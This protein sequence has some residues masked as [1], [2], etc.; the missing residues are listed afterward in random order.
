HR[1]SFVPVGFVEDAIRVVSRRESRCD[2]RWRKLRN[3]PRRIDLAVDH[4][5]IE[6]NPRRQYHAADLKTLLHREVNDENA[7]NSAR[8]ANDQHETAAPRTDE[9]GTD[10][11]G[12]DQQSGIN[13]EEKRPP[14]PGIE[15]RRPR[16]VELIV[17]D[18]AEEIGEEEFRQALPG[19]APRTDETPRKWQ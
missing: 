5:Q 1:L 11:Q 2:R 7:E 15:T 18:V 17:G 8:G 6:H 19:H 10:R 4:R 13:A 14:S 12:S 9:R 16:I 3:W